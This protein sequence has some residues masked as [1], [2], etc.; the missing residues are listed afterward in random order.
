MGDGTRAHYRAHDVDL[1]AYYIDRF[2]VTVGHFS[3]FVEATAYL[4]SAERRGTSDVFIR[5][6][7]DNRCWEPVPGAWWALPAG[8][9]QGPPASLEHPVTNVSWVD[10]DAYCRWV[11]LRLPTEAEWEKAGRGT[12]ARTYPWGDEPVE[13]NANLAHHD[14]E[15]GGT[16]NGTQPVG[17]Y[18][19]DKSP[20]GVYDLVGNV[21]EWVADYYDPD[22][23]TL[24]P[25]QNPVGPESGASRV[26]RGRNWTIGIWHDAL[27]DRRG[28][29]P[30]DSTSWTGFRCAGGVDLE[31]R[32]AVKPSSFGTIKKQ[33]RR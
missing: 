29:H 23:Y 4:T 27:W 10:A 3:A 25:V 11:D 20:Y 17:S 9:S 26:K 24:S 16:E 28:D 6:G 18:P 32:T 19:L 12:D 8:E 21:D 22:Y 14:P 33:F 2:E 15:T 7:P 1:D 31:T 13:D 5:T 30:I